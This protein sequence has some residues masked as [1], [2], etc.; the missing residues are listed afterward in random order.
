MTMEERV[1]ALE[2]EIRELKKSRQ[3]PPRLGHYAEAS[4]KCRA[5]FEEKKLT[6]QTYAVETVCEQAA[7]A[8]FKERH[9]VGYG[10]E[11]NSPA[12]YIQ[13]KEA[14]EEYVK[15]CSTLFDVCQVYLKGEGIWS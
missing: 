5:L 2:E 1:K 9:K 15:L 7:R 11:G 13:T 8:V 3:G 14:A 10:K 12:K 4:R 6:G